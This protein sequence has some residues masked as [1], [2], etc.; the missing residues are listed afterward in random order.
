MQLGNHVFAIKRL[1][2]PSSASLNYEIEALK[3]VRR[4]GR[5]N[6]HLVELLATYTHQGSLYMVFPWAEGDLHR[7][8]QIH[9]MPDTAVMPWVMDQFL[10]ITEGLARIHRMRL[11]RS[12]ASSPDHRCY[13]RHGD[14]KPGNI[15]WFKS[16]ESDAGRL[17]I[18]DFGL[19]RFHTES[20]KSRSNAAMIPVSPT[21]RAPECELGESVSSSY[22]I[23]MLGC[24]FSEFVT[25]LLLG[26]Q[27]LEEYAR[28]RLTVHD[29]PYQ[30]VQEDTFFKMGVNASGNRFA[31]VNPSV[32]KVRPTKLLIRNSD[33]TNG[34]LLSGLH[35]FA[36]IRDAHTLS[37][38]SST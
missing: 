21:Y 8:W 20:T 29:V 33:L 32:Q 12:A 31:E 28:R 11:P 38:T 5:A 15:L 30:C 1:H 2:E 6:Q 35:T 3:R 4:H 9:P 10:G 25:W 26:Q 13:G 14:L 27:G 34:Q 24:I 19:T 7:F 37:K 16:G 23:W 36:S 18:A 17:V 22:D